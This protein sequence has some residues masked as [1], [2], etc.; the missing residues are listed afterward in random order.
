MTA[1]CHE[2]EH[3]YPKQVHILDHP[4]LTTLVTQASIAKTKQPHLN[5]IIH[6]IYRELFS[7]VMANEWPCKKISIETR[8][9]EFHPEQKL[10]TSI[11]DPDQK[12][13][14]VDI[15]RAGMI[16]AQ[17][18]F[19]QLN[20]ITNPEGNR[21]DH[22]FAS[23]V[24]GDDHQV[25]HT[26]INSS[27]VGG[28]VDGAFVFIPDPM[29]ATGLSLCEVVDFYKNKN[30]GKPIKLISVHMIIT[31][32]FIRTLNQQ[33]PDVII[34]SAR[35]DRGFSSPEAL[36]KLPGELWNEEKGLNDRQYIVPGAG[37]VG[38]LINNSFV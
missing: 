14:C 26:E 36:K 24:S 33:H 3:R 7:V 30:M 16:P 11:L 27:K 5:Q 25:T 29:G 13:V 19:D 15:A 34:Y 31:P 1:I 35:L 17:V 32:E 2:I 20:G 23:R 21:L 38:E 12:A 28:N 9:S 6:S 10:Q 8:M 18:F 22:I 37:G 4:L